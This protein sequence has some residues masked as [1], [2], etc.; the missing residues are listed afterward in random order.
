MQFTKNLSKEENET[1]TCKNWHSKGKGKSF[2]KIGKMIF[3]ASLAVLMTCNS[4]LVAAQGAESKNTVG[5]P[6]NDKYSGF[7]GIEITGDYA[8][9]SNL[10]YYNAYKEANSSK[11]VISESI[12]IPTNTI[13]DNNGK[14]VSMSAHEGRD[15]FLWDDTMDYIEFPVD[16]DAASRFSIEVDYY[17]I[18]GDSNPAKRSII[19]D[20]MYPF[21]EASD[22]VFY[23]Y[24]VDEGEPVINSIGDETRPSQ[25]EVPGWKTTKLIDTSAFSPTPF[26]FTLDKGTHNVRLTYVSEDMYIS[27]IRLV[28][29]ISIPTYA[30]V[31]AEYAANGYKAVANSESSY[32]YFEA[33]TT[34]VAKNDPTLR[35]ENDGDPLASPFSGTNRKLNVIGGARWKEGNQSITWEFT[36]PET[37]LYKISIRARQHYNN[38]L[39]CYRSIAIDGEIPFEELVSY[40]F[41]YD[42]QWDTEELCDEN[43]TPYEFYLEAGTHEITM[44]VNYGI[45]VPVIESINSDITLLSG[46]IM[47]IT[48]LAGTSPDPNYDYNFM[49]KIP[50]LAEDFKTLIDSLQWKYDY[51]AGSFE[52]LPAMANNFL[53]II[54]EIQIMIDTPYKIA[55]N[56][57]DLENAMNSLSTWYLEL[58]SGPLMLDYFEICAPQYELSHETSNFFSRLWATIQ[59][60]LVSFSKDYDNVGGVLSDDVEVHT[61]LNVWVARGTE[62]AE[63]IKELADESFT[64]Q[65]GIA[66][67]VN[68]VPGSQLSSNGVNALM[69]AITSGK[70]PDVALGVDANSPGEFAIR[71]AVV[72]L[73]QFEDF[74]EVRER[75]V[76]A[77]FTSYTY[78]D[79]VYALPETMD[80]YVMFYRKDLLSEYNIQLPNTRDELYEY[81]MPLLYQNGFEFYVGHAI[82]DFTP[83]LFQ[84]GGA[85]YTEDGYTSALDSPEAFQAF[86]EFCQINTNYGVDEVVQSFYQN[87]RTGSMPIG[88]GGYALYMQLSTAA[89]E[90]SGKWGIAPIPGTLKAD[91]TIDRTTGGITQQGDIILSQSEHKEESWEFIKWWTSE[92]TQLTFAREIESIVGAEARWNTANKNA[93]LSL[94]WNKDDLKVIE[95]MWSWA[96]ETPFVLGG[97]FTTRH[98]TNAWTSVVVSNGDARDAIEAA[99]KAIN[100]EL[101]MKQEEYGIE[102][103]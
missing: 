7:Q 29:P 101:R 59:L 6:L 32:V 54:E 41:R 94:A 39:A 71:D 48:L 69:L 57:S 51:L 8:S 100:K 35:R 1:M 49:R 65:T 64:P 30:E 33:E 16:M 37:G 96:E 75:F 87:F 83:Y 43:G 15:A 26:E 56:F 62:W 76:D 28:Q 9:S 103:E 58:Q 11:S 88:L 63:A 17:L 85:F 97:Y 50:N 47:D 93:F 74:P 102:I 12:V 42:T 36:V 2:K 25:M 89:P 44:A 23:R 22:L 60:F 67:K 40:A 79:G 82:N 14:K 20:D 98:L 52:K 78:E 99:V 24:Y 3:S 92:E 31:Q 19:I 61:Q 86:L 90:L 66:I 91:G 13:K 21:V 10:S 46:I 53:T 38:G 45:L 77:V 55:K 5:V 72:D 18:E 70:A 81:V 68:V 84:N 95:E 34:A 73:T 80:F 27:E 4:L